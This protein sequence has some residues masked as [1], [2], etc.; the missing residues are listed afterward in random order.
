MSQPPSRRSSVQ[1]TNTNASR[2]L[3]QAHIRANS[4][5]RKTIS[6]YQD[7]GAIYESALDQLN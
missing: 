1:T 5:A 7:Q 3:I 6:D 2:Q 4:G